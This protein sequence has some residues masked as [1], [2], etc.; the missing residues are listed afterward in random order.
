MNNW[1]VQFP[2]HE[3]VKAAMVR[4]PAMIGENQM[5]GCFPCQIA[6]ALNPQKRWRPKGTGAPPPDQLRQPTPKLT[7]H[8]P[9][10]TSVPPG[11]NE[12]PD[13]SEID[14]VL[15]GYANIC[16]ALPCF[17]FFDC[18]ED[19]EDCQCGNDFNPD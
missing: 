5:A 8:L 16:I 3:R 15:P 11:D 10:K 12:R 7:H 6:R 14:G 2:G 9:G 4:H 17:E 1:A 19:T 18:D 13:P